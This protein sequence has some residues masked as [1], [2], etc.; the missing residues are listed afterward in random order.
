MLFSSRLSGSVPNNSNLFIFVADYD[1]G[2]T[3]VGF[4]HQS[5][6]IL[7]RRAVWSDTCVWVSVHAR[8]FLEGRLWICDGVFCKWVVRSVAFYRAETDARDSPELE[9]VRLLEPRA[10]YCFKTTANLKP[11]DLNLKRFKFKLSLLMNTSISYNIILALVNI[12]NAW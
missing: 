10:L 2:F 3:D 1:L 9:E 6:M 4:F 12:F 7:S 5:Q 8:A 11:L